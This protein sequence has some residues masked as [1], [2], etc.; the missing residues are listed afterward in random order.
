VVE[1]YLWP[2][3]IDIVLWAASGLLALK[4]LTGFIT[5]RRRM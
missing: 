4:C 1:V 5:I 2:G 3:S